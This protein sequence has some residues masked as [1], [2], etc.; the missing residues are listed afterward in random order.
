[1]GEGERQ[2]TCPHGCHSPR[3]AEADK[4]ELGGDTLS[5]QRLKSDAS[6]S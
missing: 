6:L 2:T 4:A 1:M 3:D 5:G